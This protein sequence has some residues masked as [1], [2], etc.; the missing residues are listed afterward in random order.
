MYDGSSDL[1][2]IN[3]FDFKDSEPDHP[4][5]QVEQS[6]ENAEQVLPEQT[7][8]GLQIDGE[9]ESPPEGWFSA[10]EAMDQNGQSWDMRPHLYDRV[11]KSQLLLDS[12][13]QVTAY[14]PEPGDTVDSSITLKAVNGTK[15]KCFGYKDVEVQI[16][17]KTYN[18][19]AI[20]TEV[21]NPI[22]GWNFVRKHRLTMD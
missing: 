17:R 8:A 14:P 13:A 18:I 4:F 6:H 2:E 19:R 5:I 22:L 3:E 20:K 15:L 7:V 1:Q 10:I 11:T 16:N 21:K 9:S 12:G